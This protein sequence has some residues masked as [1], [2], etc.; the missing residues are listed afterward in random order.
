MAPYYAIYIL[1]LTLTQVN[2]LLFIKKY[3]LT[4]GTSLRSN[5]LFM[6]IN[7]I[8]AVVVSAVTLAVQQV[9]FKATTYSVCMATLIVSISAVD[10]IL[11]LKAYEKG[12]VAIVNIFAIVG[13]IILSCLWGVLVLHE[14]LSP[15]RI[16][17]IAIML[18][19]VFVVS[20]AGQTKADKRLLGIYLAVSLA[21][22]FVSI[23]SK[24]HQVETAYQTV[25]TLSF[26]IWIGIVRTL[27]FAIV[28]LFLFIKP[29]QI[30]QPIPKSASIYAI[31]SSTI[32]GIGYVLSLVANSMLPI[33]I[34]SPLSV[35]F[36]LVM[37]AV[38][39]WIFYKERLTKR[40][41]FGTGLALMGTLLFVLV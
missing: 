17:A 6:V 15:L 7:G 2:G 30:E 27:L 14:T 37:S 26:S 31:G 35:G 25:D 32:S 19:S 21:T 38:L 22:A 24:Q 16:I 23:F 33:V 8:V 28:G 11:R 13:S 12:Q 5:T 18:V 4:A 40:Q 29:N 41:W 20:Y 36:G 10:T 34:T 39:P 1:S 3:Q 9:S